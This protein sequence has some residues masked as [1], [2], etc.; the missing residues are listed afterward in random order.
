MD[1]QM[2]VTWLMT[3]EV[4]HGS[5]WYGHSGHSGHHLEIL[6]LLIVM[7][8]DVHFLSDTVTSNM[9]LSS[10]HIFW[11]IKTCGP[12]SCLYLEK[13]INF[14][15][16]ISYM[17]M[18]T[19]VSCIILPPSFLNTLSIMWSAGC[20]KFWQLGPPSRIDIRLQHNTSLCF[21]Q[22]YFYGL[23]VKTIWRTKAFQNS[24]EVHSPFSG[25][26]LFLTV[27][28][29]WTVKSFNVYVLAPT[30]AQGVTL[31]VFP[32]LRWQVV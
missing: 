25:S 3:S 22:I 32:F 15:I 16:I 9:L 12:I 2:S 21:I 30:G 18:H 23:T 28:T 26:A 29:S 27:E 17:L 11:H 20:V 19:S 6:W 7:G 14:H 4:W 8:K 31:S 13:G 24:T 5:A 1:W 10:R